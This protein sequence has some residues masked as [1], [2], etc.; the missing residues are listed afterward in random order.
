M[1]LRSPELNDHAHILRGERTFASLQLNVCGLYDVGPPVDLIAHVLGC[2]FSRAAEDFR[3][4][5]LQAIHQLGLTQR[6]VHVG[7]DLVD[8]GTFE[9]V[10]RR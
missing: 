8:V 7:I 1:R 4:Q 10:G 5:F 2:A 6:F 3:G 9:R